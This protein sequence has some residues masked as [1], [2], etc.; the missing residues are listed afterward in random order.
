[1]KVEPK[2]LMNIAIPLE[3]AR[4]ERRAGLSPAGV[5]S[6]VAG[7]HRVYVQSRAGL[8]SGFTDMDYAAAGGRIV[9]S[10]EEALGRAA[11]VLSVGPPSAEQ[12][13]SLGTEHTWAG[14]LH[15]AVAPS[16]VMDDLL[17]RGTTLIDY[18]TIETDDG[19]LPAQA[20]MSELAGRMSVHVAATLLQNDGAGLGVLLSG[21]PGVPPADVVIV[22]GGVVGTSAAQC[23]AGL[24]ARVTLLDLNPEVLKRVD[25]NLRGRVVTMAANTHN[26]RKAVAFADVLVV[27]VLI[28]GERAPRIVTR[29]MVRRMRPR[30]VILD[31]S[32]DQGGAVETSRLTTLQDPTFV[33]E[34]VIH[35][36]VPNMPSAVGRTATHAMTNA[37]LPFVHKI[38][39][40]GVAPAA[41]QDPTLARGVNVYG[42]RI[43]NA[44]LAASSRRSFEPLASLLR[45]A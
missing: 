15:L 20:P 44:G 38:A 2:K 25:D 43:T 34:G 5:E 32:I 6:L 18:E 26:L 4:G 40:L 45:H 42:G 24:G 29:D 21:L 35:Y 37:I 39:D 23:F 33:E 1:L 13:P 16:T 14:Y 7:G 30:S 3:S 22:G 27:A 10:A 28:R 19:V 9:H 11:L 17:A 31:I 12:L 41:Q 36:C 8:G